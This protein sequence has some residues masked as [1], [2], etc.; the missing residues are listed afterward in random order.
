MQGDKEKTKLPS[1]SHQ[2]GKN[3][4]SQHMLL[5]S[6]NVYNNVNCVQ[7]DDIMGKGACDDSNNN[8]ESV[9]ANHKN[10]NK[11]I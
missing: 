3:D 8:N 6:P 10:M 1:S 11:K 7:C 2:F 4:L 5:L 9:S